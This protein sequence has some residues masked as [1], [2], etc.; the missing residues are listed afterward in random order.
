[1]TP[2]R[3][4]QLQ[5]FIAVMQLGSVSRAAESLFLTQP[6]VTKLLR[7]LEEETGLGLFD[8]RRR[9]L[10]PTHEARRFE[11][12]VTRFFAAARQ[13]DRLASNMRGAGLGELRVAA[14]PSLGIS[15]VPRLLARFA[16]EAQGLRVA[17]TVASSLEVHELVQSGQ[18]DL[19]F[20]NPVSAGGAMA[21]APPIPLPGVLVLPLRHRL[22]RRRVVELRELEGEPQVSLGRQYRLR[23]L[24]DEM[25]ER[26]GV[27]T[28]S[29]AET[30]SAAAACEMVAEGLGFAIVDAVTAGRYEGRVVTVAVRPAIDFPVQ[31]LAPAGRPM[32]VLAARFLGM[33]QAAMPDGEDRSG[34]WAAQMP[35]GRC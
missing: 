3:Y 5:A 9:R 1:M 19:G 16:R 20:A 23:D 28:V 12:E 32:S 4:H 15:F 24:V 13:V 31:V 8:R 33:V 11:Q 6:A 21:G 2:R 26:H 7:A 30:Q 25:F 10:V 17:M 14:M 27:A 29:V 34:R 18:V 22:A 35:E